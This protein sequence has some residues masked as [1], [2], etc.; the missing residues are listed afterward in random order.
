MALPRAK[1]RPCS[2]P[3]LR[4]DRLLGEHGIQQN[5]PAGWQEFER[6]KSHPM[7]LALA[8]RLRQQTTRSVKQIAARLHVGKRESA[9]G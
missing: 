7:K 9:R 5:T 3:A 2:A 8:A 1:P 6:Q 4:A